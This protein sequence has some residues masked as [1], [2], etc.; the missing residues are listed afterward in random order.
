[1]GRWKEGGGWEGGFA[2]GVDGAMVSREGGA[3]GLV[4]LLQG[5]ARW[6]LQKRGDLSLRPSELNNLILIE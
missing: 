2:E 3:P 1:M 5:R 4:P 6:S